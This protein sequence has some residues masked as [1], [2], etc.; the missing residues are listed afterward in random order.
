GASG[1]FWCAGASQG[2][3]HRSHLA[4]LAGDAEGDLLAV[5][6]Y[7][8]GT[9]L[10]GG[11]SGFDEAVADTIDLHIELAPFFGQCLGQ[12]GD[13]GLGG[14]II[15]LSGI[16]IDAGDR[17]D[18]D[19]LARISATVGSD[20]LLGSVAYEGRGLAQNAERSGG[21]NIHHGVPLLI[22]HF[23][24]DAIPGV[25]GVI[26][27]NVDGAKVFER[28]VDQLRWKRRAGDIARDN[29]RFTT[30]SANGG[31]SL[32]RGVGIEIAD[33]DRGPFRSEQAGG[34]R[35]NTAPRTGDNGY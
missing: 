32:L 15:H 30:R 34:G 7:L 20:F 21:V 6:L 18:I 31:G 28:R 4:H 27:N 35:T 9:L 16:A 33:N 19:H 8:L 2:N 13:T 3:E 12:T 23:M 24:N 1:L 26:D 17:G 14:G 25:A 10:S 5:A 29:N 11:Q 22:G